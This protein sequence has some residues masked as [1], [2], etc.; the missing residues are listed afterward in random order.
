VGTVI[1]LGTAVTSTT[2]I[3]I[4]FYGERTQLDA[5]L[6]SIETHCTRYKVHIV[7]N[8]KENVGF[9]RGVNKGILNGS[10]P[11]VWLLNQDAIVLK[12]AQEALI[13]RL[14]NRSQ[15]GIAG[16]M[17]IDP[18]DRDFITHGG[19][20]R[21]F[22]TGLHRGGRLS[23]GEC[24]S[25]LEQSWVNFASVMLKREMIDRIGLLDES[26][27][28]FYSDSDYCYWARYN[29]WQV[30]YEPDSRVL[31]RLNVSLTGSEWQTKDMFVFM[32][33]WG[34]RLTPEIVKACT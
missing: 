20:L 14:N 16:S 30:W 18:D 33:K 31:H 32:K 8:N 1:L 13:T 29:G 12:G 15:A 2:D 23:K 3:V 22:P 19:T 27:F 7:D 10:A 24:L 6:A 28:L 21:A 11:Y 26:M 17:Q 4:V 5:C 9:T 34:L 25:P